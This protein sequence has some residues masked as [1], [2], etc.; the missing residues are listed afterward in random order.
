VPSDWPASVD[1]PGSDTFEVTAKAWLLDLLPDLRLHKVS[2]YPLALAVIARH[3]V[4]G[5]VEGDR[6]GYR[7]ARSELGEDL[8]PHAVEVALAAYVAEGRRLAAAAKALD[9]VLSALRREI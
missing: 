9:L 2:R 8:P 6:K 7:I 1:P 5:A 3:Q 4:E